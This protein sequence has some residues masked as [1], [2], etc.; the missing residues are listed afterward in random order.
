M[1]SGKPS[2]HISLLKVILAGFFFTFFISCTVVKKYQPGK[3]FVYKTNINLI[4][5]F[6][7]VEK[8]NLEAGLADQLDDSMQARKL[9]KLLW[10]TLKQPPVYDSINAD[11]SILFMRALL[12]SLG[13]F[14]DSIYYTHSVKYEQPDQYRTTVDFY[15]RPGKVVK[16]DSISYNLRHTNLQFLTDSTKSQAVIKK[17]D[18][19]AKAPISAEFDRLTELYRNTGYFRF[20]RDELVGIWDTLDV[21]LLQPTLDP[22]EQ[23]EL[24]QKLQERRNN[25]TA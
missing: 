24:L 23:L 2:T 4:G 6:S 10:S 7:K 8:Q 11:N 14:N 12:N 22:F 19:F 20:S 25:P 13:Y 1:L 3:P 16:L 9:N 5:N 18:P 17:G 21:A 15:V